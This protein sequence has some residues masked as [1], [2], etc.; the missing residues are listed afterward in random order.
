MENYEILN[1]STVQNNLKMESILLYPDTLFRP[2]AHLKITLQKNP[3]ALPSHNSSN[4]GLFG[5]IIRYNTFEQNSVSASIKITFLFFQWQVFS[6]LIMQL[7]CKHCNNHPLRVGSESLHFK[8]WKW[9]ITSG[10]SGVGHY[11]TLHSLCGTYFR[12]IGNEARHLVPPKAFL[13]LQVLYIVHFRYFLQVLCCT[14][15]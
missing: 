7:Q 2:L 9:F 8:Y 13:S 12:G 5:S 10:S 3:M 15:T 11:Y 4:L 6:L 14:T 1:V